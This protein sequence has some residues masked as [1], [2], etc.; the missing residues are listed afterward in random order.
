MNNQISMAFIVEGFRWVLMCSLSIV[1]LSFLSLNSHGEEKNIPNPVE[2]DNYR[3][4]IACGKKVTVWFGERVA[5]VLDGENISQRDPK[6]M[7]KICQSMDEIFDAYDD[8][9][10]RKPRLRA[11]IKGRIIIEVSSRVGGGLAH[12]GQLGVGIGDGFFKNLYKRV[13]KGEN[14]YDQVFFYEIARNYWMRDMN[15]PIDYHTSKGPDDWGWWTVGFNNAMS[16]VL[17]KEVDSIS[18]MYY[19][20]SN[21]EAFA[22]GMEANLDVY[23]AH[24]EKYNWT[25]SWCVPLVPWKERTSLNDLMTGLLLRLQR[26]HGGG[27]FMKGLYREIPKQRPLPKSR[28]DYQATRDNFYAAASLAAEKDLWMF[29]TKD[30]RWEISKEA[31]QRVVKSLNSKPKP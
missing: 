23:L 2:M 31:H 29:F 15:P 21:G 25:N 24:P 18:D 19:F 17:P 5:I 20:G 28:S 6:V 26:E 30:L 9:T 22:K 4:F 7:S 16:V 3:A 12:H 13:E 8:V 14:T 27:E 1:C 10:G 11:Q